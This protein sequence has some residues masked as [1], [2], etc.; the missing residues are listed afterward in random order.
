MQLAVQFNL[1][2]HQMDVKTAYLNAPIECEL[3]VEQPEGFTVTDR[4]G[5]HLVYKLQKSLYGLKQS[6][7]NWNGV[8]RSYLV[9]QGFI[10]SQ[11]D[12]C[13]YTKTTDKS[14]AVVII[15]VDSSLDIVQ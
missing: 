8:L 5:E 9:S 4:R 2:V 14:M 7:R 6:G 1:T 13:V 12:N 15:W 3:Y 10:Q 11:A